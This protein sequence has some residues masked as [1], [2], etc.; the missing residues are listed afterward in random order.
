MQHSADM[1]PEDVVRTAAIAIEE[2]RWADLIP[3]VA[4]E[5]LAPFTNSFAESLRRMAERTPRTAEEIRAE[6]PWLPLAVAEFHAEE[7][8]VA[9]ERGLPQLLRE[10]GVSDFSELNACT[11]EELFV[12]YMAANSPGARL[13][14]AWAVSH[15]PVDD[16]EA[17]VAKYPPRPRRMTVVGSV[18]EDQYAH[19]VFR[20]HYGDDSASITPFVRLTTLVRTPGGWRLQ[21][22]GSLLVQQ[23]WMRAYR[24][25]DAPAPDETT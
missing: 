14:H 25:D 1:S 7:E 6:Q 18:V 15:T 4:P 16:P 21:M 13:R 12:R 20:E 17:E 10:W 19:V 9:I 24:P 3:L 22:D 11:P 2:E 23:G 5:A 8:R